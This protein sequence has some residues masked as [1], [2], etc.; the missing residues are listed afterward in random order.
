MVVGVTCGLMAALCQCA[1]YIFSKQFTR[2]KGTSLQLLM[3]SHAIMGVIA[4]V[5]VTILLLQLKISF[6]SLGNCWIHVFKVNAFYLGAQFCCFFALTKTE[7]SRLAPLLG[8]KILFIALFGIFLF[9][10]RM[11]SLQWVAVMLCLAGA[12]MA[13]WSGGAVPISGIICILLACAGY[14]LSNLNTKIVIDIIPIESLFLSSLLCAGLAFSTLG[15]VSLLTA[16]MMPQF[17]AAHIKPALPFSF[18]WLT[19]M[20]LLFSCIG[21]VGPLYGNILQSSRGVLG[22]LLGLIIAKFTSSELEKRLPRAVVVLRILAAVA[23]TTAAV[24]YVIA[25]HIY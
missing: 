4:A 10:H 12:F 6:S 14:S 23:I 21:Q 19:A 9:E 8:M 3:V 16:V 15:A 11:L 24:L 17:K 13:N 1:S 7:A 25:E 5:G 2:D 18:A 22:V 20:V